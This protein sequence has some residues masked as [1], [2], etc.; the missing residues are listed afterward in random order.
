[1][2]ISE[3]RESKGNL[4][5]FGSATEPEVWNHEQRMRRGGRHITS[6]LPFIE[7]NRMT[8]DADSMH[9]RHS[10]RGY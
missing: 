4:R 2:F 10:I 3:A 9:G 7:L 8:D 5:W 6:L 1:M